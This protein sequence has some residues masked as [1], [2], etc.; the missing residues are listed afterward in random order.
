MTLLSRAAGQA[1]D[2]ALGLPARAEPYAVRADV[3]VPMPDGVVLLGDHYRPAGA[4]GPL[5]VV[6]IRTPYGRRGMTALLFA[7]PLARRGF[8]LFIQST[9]GTFGSGG[10]FRPFRHERHDGLATV[11]WLREQP[12]CDGQVSTTGGSYLGHTQWAVAPYADPPLRSVSLNVTAANMSACFYAHGAPSLKNALDWSGMIGRQE[13][14]ALAAVPNPR[15]LAQARR[16][17]RKVPLQAADVDVAGAPVAF[18]RDFTGHA[19]PG[20]GFWA[21][22]DHDRADLSR[23]PPVSM[24]TGWWDLFLPQQLR[25]YAAI[26]AAGVSARILVGPWRH[27][28]PAEMRATARQDIAWLDHHLRGGPAPPGAP[29]RVFL[30]QAGTWL[31]FDEWP[32]P[33][34][35]ATTYYLRGAG[36]ASTPDGAGA[37]GRLARDTEPGA[38]APGTFVYDPADPTPSVGGPFLQPPAKQADNATL[39]A[40]PDVLTY[41]SGPFAAPIDLAGPVRARVFVRT[42]REHADLFVRVCD[43]DARGVSRN[44]ADGIRRLSPA[45]VPAPDVQAGDDGVLAVDVELFPTAYRVGPGHRIRVQVSGGAFPRFARNFGTPEPFG[46]A[47]RSVPC[48]FEIHADAQHPSCVVLPVLPPAHI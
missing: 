7:A 5:P 29:V 41:T 48:R 23:L 3:A 35:V 36:G 39:E 27:G 21:E 46:T 42:G 9:R 30:Q 32:P 24:V 14:G 1:V 13:R 11:A 34:S 37:P 47:T 18:W 8:Q 20:D 4:G 40:R 28:E 45:T 6:L 26:R 17:V 2:R 38:A 10:Q 31:D 33:A 44:V 22:A 19:A 43:V 16:A 12:W 25:D 15:R